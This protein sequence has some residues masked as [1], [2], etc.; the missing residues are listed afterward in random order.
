MICSSSAMKLKLGEKIFCWKFFS[1]LSTRKFVDAPF[2][3]PLV[4][5]NTASV[6]MIV[7]VWKVLKINISTFH[8]VWWILETLNLIARSATTT[9]FIAIYTHINLISFPI[10]NFYN[11]VSWLATDNFNRQ[12]NKLHQIFNPPKKKYKRRW[13]WQQ[14]RKI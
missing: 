3:M 4:C 12:Q 13:W 9:S 6:K 10:C 8:F 14:G 7:C 2:V 11:F 5:T 1:S